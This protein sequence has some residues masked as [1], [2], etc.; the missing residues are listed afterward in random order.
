MEVGGEEWTLYRLE[1]ESGGFLGHASSGPALGTVVYSWLIAQPTSRPCC[2]ALRP[3]R[4]SRRVASGEAESPLR[5]V[6]LSRQNDSFRH[7]EIEQKGGG[8]PEET[9][10]LSDALSWKTGKNR[11]KETRRYLQNAASDWLEI[12]IEMSGGAH[13]KGSAIS[14]LHRNL[15]FP[16]PAAGKITW[17]AIPANE[18]GDLPS[19]APFEA[20]SIIS[21]HAENAS[22]GACLLWLCDTPIRVERKSPR[23][24]EVCYEQASQRHAL[25]SARLD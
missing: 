5:R 9:A 18:L 20:K 15:S 8:D 22:E 25:M 3:V 4:Q 14:D 16:N 7:V 1:D 21:F 2:L 11:S 6:W 10:I 12:A 23:A 13:D 19:P 24:F 17:R